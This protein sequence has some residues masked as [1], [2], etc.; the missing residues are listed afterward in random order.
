MTPDQKQ[1]RRMALKPIEQ[2]YRSTQNFEGLLKVYDELILMGLAYGTFGKVL[3][4][5]LYCLARL[6]RIDEVN[7]L[8]AEN[9]AILHFSMPQNELYRAATL[10]SFFTT[11][12]HSP[13]VQKQTLVDWLEDSETFEEVREIVF[14]YQ[15]VIAGLVLKSMLSR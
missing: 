9:K 2:E 12:Q 8:L 5:K 7:K 13:Q 3:F 6:K 11:N 14:D 4:K 10:I 15:A 1:E